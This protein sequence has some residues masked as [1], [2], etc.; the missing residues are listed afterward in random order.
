MDF[1]LPCSL[2]CLLIINRRQNC[3]VQSR[4][5]TKKFVQ[6]LRGK[7][8]QV[9][10]LIDAQTTVSCNP[11]WHKSLLHTCC[12]FESEWAC[13]WRH[14]Y[15]SLRICKDF[16]C[17]LKALFHMQS[18]GLCSCEANSWDWVYLVLL[19]RKTQSAIFRILARSQ[20]FQMILVLRGPWKNVL[21]GM[22]LITMR[23]MRP[24]QQLLLTGNLRNCRWFCVNDPVPILHLLRAWEGKLVL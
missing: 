21:S 13:L 5:Y 22:K 24:Y 6:A 9:W 12:A 2:F 17:D 14:P 18:Q 20:S 7:Q 1:K 11:I 8:M 16:S 19:F 15:P 4:S 23:K 3:S 10:D